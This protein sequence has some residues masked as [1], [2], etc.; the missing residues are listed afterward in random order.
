MATFAPA[1]LLVSHGQE[2]LCRR[3]CTEVSGTHRQWGP[4]EQRALV[5]QLPVVLERLYGWLCF[6]SPGTEEAL[7]R[8]FHPSGPL[9]SHLVAWGAPAF[10]F[11]LQRLPPRALQAA[12]LSATEVDRLDAFATGLL[13]ARANQARR[14]QGA[15]SA[16]FAHLGSER[17]ARSP[18]GD[19]T[20]LCLTGQEFMLTCLVHFVVSDGVT[21]QGQV[22]PGGSMSS[23]GG[24][25]TRLGHGAGASG[26]LP[27]TSSAGSSG[28]SLLGGSASTHG[29]AGM[30]GMT[31]A[32]S[33]AHNP[34]CGALSVSYERLFVAYLRAHLQHSEYE[35]AHAHEPRIV[36]FFLN[37]LHEFL[38]APRSPLEAT[39][40][41]SR[42]DTVFRDARVQPGALHALRLLVIH[43]LANPALRRGCAEVS[44]AGVVPSAQTARLTRE[45][46]LI[47]PD[48]IEF[49]REL[50]SCLAV[51]RS[52]GL[53][54]L[55]SIMRLWLVVLQPWL[56]P[57]LYSWYLTVRSPEPLLEPPPST[58]GFQNMRRMALHPEQQPDLAL[59]GLNPD[60]VTPTMPEASLPLVPRGPKTTKGAGYAPASLLPSAGDARS[61][62]S[63]VVKFEDAYL[64][65]DA[66]LSI[67]TN[68]DICVRLGCSLAGVCSVDDV[69]AG[70]PGAGVGSSRTSAHS[71]APTA[72]VP[73]AEQL[74]RPRHI[75]NALETMAQALLCFSDPQ[76]LQ[77]LAETPP[78][79]AS[80]SSPIFAE[81][82]GLHPQTVLSVS[83]VW[84][85][86]LSA[87]TNP[88]LSA[89]MPI[90]SQGL[91]CGPQWTR[92]SSRPVK[93]QSFTDPSRCVCYGN[94][95]QGDKSLRRCQASRHP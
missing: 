59:I 13:D 73:T 86:L 11:P 12:I 32:A 22:S 89:I 63:Y 69:R 36:R 93:A 38:V 2:E 30:L 54:R 48:L 49:L 65:L 88:E 41:T 91:Q 90:L 57:R 3:F 58:N 46:A 39:S 42:I 19:M 85:A 29:G 60:A 26:G 84:M 76:L 71:A 35:L 64:L 74:L 43:L 79:K 66:F 34:K 6:T 62:R 80:S 77:I 92:T 87:R 82:G 9:A 24:S 15:G 17:L 20:G 40:T 33:A 52:P 67:P 5:D 78:Q 56:A 81:D 37:L 70:S 25:G 18:T 27:W 45:V 44:R 1:N 95:T 51:H 23:Q 83:V 47:M 94:L 4:S 61:W 31:W 14:L 28:L 53:E 21:G 7:L 72:G 10:V 75:V 50:V 8:T 55:T 16:W 68:R